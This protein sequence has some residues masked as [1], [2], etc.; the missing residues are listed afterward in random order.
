MTERFRV[1]LLVALISSTTPLFAQTQFEGTTA[2]GAFYRI[3][4]PDNWNGGLVIW[5][6][7]F[8]LDPPGPLSELDLG[9]LLPVQ[10]SQG[11]AV[12]AS[13]YRQAGW[14]VFKS[15][16]DLQSL[17]AA[18]HSRVG[19][20]SEVI[21][22]GA[23]L[24]GAVTAA[25]L[26]KANLGN[27]T[28]ALTFCGAMAGS[29]NWDGA[30]DLRLAYDLICSGV[31]GAAIE[32]GAKGLPKG[33][34]L[35]QSDVEAAVN[36]CTGVDLPKRQRSQQQKTNLAQ[37]LE[38]TQLPESFLQTVMGFATLAMAD[39]THDRGKLKGKQALGNEDV[40]YGD[41]Q[42]N[43][44]IERVSPKRG[45]ARKL[46]RN[47][48][49]KGRVGDTRIISIHTDKDGLVIVEN[50][51]EYA[52]VVPPENLTVAVAVEKQPSHCEF[53][54]AEVVGSWET[55]RL[56]LDGAP[57]PQPDDLQDACQAIEVLF[58]GPCRFDPDFVIPDMDGRIRPR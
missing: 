4:V 55:L 29:R 26:E 45:P 13:S 42:I 34:E 12:A 40:D 8:D 50:Q 49:P 28:G 22:Y 19:A 21:L 35:G 47:F 54:F 18:F 23:S 51:S 27:V 5:N 2:G 14:A 24:G 33:S 10:L 43:D 7:G 44:A 9:P 56:W 52:S 6:H 53:T 57:Q 20:P 3:A 32:G 36:A 16:K 1:A 41:D 17:V 15:S 38:L 31:P 48:T 25:A 58:P 30:L 11:Y 39:L 46:A 37:L